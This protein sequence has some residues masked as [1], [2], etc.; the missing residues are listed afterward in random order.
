MNSKKDLTSTRRIY[1]HAACEN[2]EGDFWSPEQRTW[3]YIFATKSFEEQEAMK[4]ELLRM[5]QE[6]PERKPGQ[7]DADYMHVYTNWQERVSQYECL[8][9]VLP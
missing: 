2:E 9:N 1:H 7:T 4:A 8:L 5:M 3:D 6:V